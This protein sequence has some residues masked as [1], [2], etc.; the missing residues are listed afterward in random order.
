MKKIILFTDSLGA[1]GAQRQLVGLA[2]L[3]NIEKYDVTVLTYHK[4]EFYI[5]FL[6]EDN[7]KYV[8]LNGLN[9]PIK[10]IYSIIQYIRKEGPDVVIAY[11]ETPSLIA[12]FV[13]LFCPKIKVVVSERNTTQIVNRKDKIRF[14]L[15]RYVD[16]IVPNSYSQE[17]FLKQN[18]PNYS[19]KITTITNFVD[20][21]KYRPNIKDRNEVHT[22]MVAATIFNSKNTLLFID[23]VNILKNKGLRFVV[24][25]YGYSDKYNEYYNECINKIEKYSL[26]KHIKLLPKTLEI[27]KCY[28]EADYF[29][30]PSFF[31]GT[32]NV[33]C[34]AI[35][36][37]LPVA[38]SN[39]C[40]NSRYVRNGENGY[41]FDPLSPESIADA[42]QS[43]LSLTDSEYKS[44]SLR[45]RQ[46]AEEKLHKNLFCQKYIE[47]IKG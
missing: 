1:G 28:N 17:S 15:Y 39:V 4:F 32:P 8:L 47:L 24:K 14:F 36:S 35:A 40:D 43:M 38:C 19:N 23:A 2:K 44:Y 27:E 26:S 33:I 31:E 12:S 42:L 46:I 3:L 9:N 30:L 41:L 7:I 11:Q 16:K 6:Q 20:L 18:Y 25:W 45:S 13:K 22:I 29:C 21:E 34:E 37:G 5:P 10:R